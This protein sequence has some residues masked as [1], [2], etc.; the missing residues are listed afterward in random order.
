LGGRPRA[1]AWLGARVR[2]DA[3][4]FAGPMRGS[5]LTAQDALPC[6]RCPSRIKGVRQTGK[7]ERGDGRR[8][9]AKMR[10]RPRTRAC[11]G[12]ECARGTHARSTALLD[13]RKK[14][15]QV[16]LHHDYVAEEG[17]RIAD[18]GMVCA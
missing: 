8:A 6:A 12:S 14:P 10:L 3:W 7:E 13:A 9:R 18:Q 11:A 16:T 15:T 17:V 2:G 5:W 4:G 1:S